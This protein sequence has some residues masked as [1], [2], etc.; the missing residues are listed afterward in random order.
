MPKWEK[1]TDR[2]QNAREPQI[3]PVALWVF[4][5]CDLE[6]WQMTLKNMLFY[7]IFECKLLDIAP[8]S[9]TAMECV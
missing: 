4:F 6:I 2:D 7:T 3:W 5:A 8:R 1:S 9:A